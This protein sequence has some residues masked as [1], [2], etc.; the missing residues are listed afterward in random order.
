M[1]KSHFN[2]VYDDI[3]PPE[4]E[5]EPDM[6]VVIVKKENF[7]F[8]QLSTS[9]ISVGCSMLGKTA[10]GDGYDPLHC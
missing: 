7:T 6:P 8:K 5:E 10:E 2:L 4:V 1:L 9:E 3:E